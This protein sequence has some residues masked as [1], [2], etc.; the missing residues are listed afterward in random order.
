M[1]RWSIRTKLLA[2]VA[3]AVA[4]T[5]AATLTLAVW[6][7]ISSYG[8]LKRDS[9]F[10]AAQL[11][12]AVVHAETAARDAEAVRRALRDVPIPPGVL[13]ARVLGRD[14]R[15]LAATGPA[16]TPR[17]GAWLRASDRRVPLDVLAG[18]EAF[19]LNAPIQHQGAEV[20]TIVVIGVADDLFEQ[21]WARSGGMISISAA[22]LAI[23]LLFAMRLLGRMLGPLSELSET[24]SRVSRRHDYTVS[25]DPRGSDEVSSLV[26]SFNMM[27]EE[28]RHR[29]NRLKRHSAELEHAVA[30]RTREFRAARDIAEAASRAKS[31][32]LATMSHEIRT[33]MNGILVTAELLAAGS[34]PPRLRRHAEVIARSGKSLLAIIN[35]ILDFSKIEAGR[36]ELE[37][38]PADPAEIVDQTLAL[39]QERARAAGLDLAARIEMDAPARIKADTARLTQV[40]TN[41]VGN[42]IKFTRAGHILVTVRQ[43]RERPDHIRFDVADT[44][45]GIRRDR[46]ATI[47]DAFTQADQSV[48]RRFGGTG[49]GL[50]I[51]KRLVAAM[52]GRI[53]VASELGVGSTFSILLPARAETRILP[54][55]P[56]AARAVVCLRGEATTA[57]ANYYLALC[58]FVV[59]DAREDELEEACRGAAFALIDAERLQHRARLP[60]ACVAALGGADALEESLIASQRADV[61]LPRPL[62]RIDVEDIVSCLASGVAPRLARARAGHD[63]TLGG[64]AGR[65][66]L[67]VDDNAVNRE[68]ASAALGRFQLDIDLAESGESAV[69]IAAGQRYDIIFMDVSMPGM[70]GFEATRRIRADEAAQQRKPTPIVA[71]TAQIAGAEADAWRAAGMNG[72]LLKPYTMLAIGDCLAQWL[73]APQ[74]AED[75]PRAVEPPPPEAHAASDDLDE[76]TIGQLAALASAGRG[77]VLTRVIGLYAEHTPKAL[78]DIDIALRGSAAEE[79]ARAAHAL[80]S[81]S[82]NVGA[83][84]VAAACADV[85]RLSRERRL[86]DAAEI[87]RALPGLVRGAMAALDKLSPGAAVAPSGAGRSAA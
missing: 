74:P 47:F 76:A 82:Y 1:S 81:M 6:Q 28:I 14:G 70:D 29:D 46:I 80:K 78:S 77:D 34:L 2:L 22:M 11:Y 9:L 8:E 59:R 58:G 7:D 79:A 4:V 16:A 39:F 5:Q 36:L 10:G 53:V 44:G 38:A 84:K 17:E 27:I 33:P 55:M 48:A 67:V 19:G 66:A 61:S 3:G 12:A 42:A 64:Y 52:K 41:L 71:L 68:V 73:G 23:A 30:E 83:R 51:A 63:A 26:A 87:A 24:M 18:R 20:G 57:T 65:R 35:D 37:L 56:G 31:D 85:E 43:D 60:A 72:L 21:I 62:S 50:A 69:L 75:A 86:S 32:F 40:L 49:L 45:V 25:L 15:T 13:H 54:F